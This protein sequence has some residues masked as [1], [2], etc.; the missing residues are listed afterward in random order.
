MTSDLVNIDA[1]RAVLS[2]ILGDPDNIA[3][4]V[5]WLPV[6]A[7]G[8]GQCRAVYL[9]MTRLWERRVPAT[10]ATVPDALKIRP[11][12]RDRMTVFLAELSIRAGWRDAQQ[13]TYHGD[14]IL[15]LARRRAGERAAAALVAV[16]P[17]R[18][19][20]GDSRRSRGRVHGAIAATVV[21]RAPRAGRADRGADVGRDAG[22]GDARRGPRDPGGADLDG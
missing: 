15:E 3:K 2:G 8:D 17:P 21:R 20:P 16:P 18:R 9:A 7:F 14:L 1:E 5:D 22:R 10:V 19:W 12:Q 13:V 6:D 4:V 11:D